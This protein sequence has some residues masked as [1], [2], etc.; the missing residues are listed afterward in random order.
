MRYIYPLV[1]VLFFV[2]LAFAQQ[3]QQVVEPIQQSQLLFVENKGQIADMKGNAHPEILFTT[4]SKSMKLFIT[5]TSIDYQFARTKSLKTQTNTQD[6]TD[7]FYQNQ[8][9]DDSTEIH[10]H[11]VFMRLKDANPKPQIIR[12]QKNSYY[13]NY[14]LPQC[15]TGVTHVSTYEKITFKNVYQNIDWVLYT[16]NGHLKYDFIVHP[17]ANQKDIKLVYEGQDSLLLL[18]DGSLKIVTTLGI[19]Q[20][21]APVIYQQNTKISGAYQL[22]GN[23]LSF[24]IGK[25]NNLLPLTIDPE[26]LWGTY[27]G[28]NGDQDYMTGSCADNKN[29]IYI[30]GSTTST[31]GIALNGHINVY[32][33]GFNDAYLVKFDEDGKRLWA[34]YF[35]GEWS[36]T[37]AEPISDSNLDAYLIF[38]S[39]ST[40][41]LKGTRNQINNAGGFSDNYI[42]K[43]NKDGIFLWGTFYGGEDIDITHSVS[44]DSKSNLLIS[45]VTRSK[46]GIS[47]N[48]YLNTSKSNAWSNSSG[49]FS[50]FDS[51]GNL[52]W[53]SYFGDV[54]RE[55][56]VDNNDDIII[57]GECTSLT[58]SINYN[59]FQSSI[60][61]TGQYEGDAFLAKFSSN[62]NIIWGTYYGGEEFDGEATCSIDEQGNCYLVGRTRSKM[63]IS[64]NGIKNSKTGTFEDGFIT[65]FNKSGQRLWATYI[66]GDSSDGFR[67]VKSTSS[68]DIYVI[69]FTNNNGI[70]LKNPFLKASIKSIDVFDGYIAKL[71]TNGQ[72]EWATLFGSDK[73]DHITHLNLDKK[74]NLLITGETDE[75][76][77]KDFNGFRPEYLGNNNRGPFFIKIKDNPFAIEKVSPVKTNYCVGE[78]LKLTYIAEIGLNTGNIFTFQLSDSSGSF[79]NPLNISTK[80][81]TKKGIDSISITLPNSILSG[82]KYR[83]RVLASD[84]SDI[85]SDY[86][87][88]IIENPKLSINFKG[89]QAACKGDTTVLKAPLYSNYTYQW[90]KDGSIINNE[91]QNTLKT[92]QAGQYYLLAFAPSGCWAFSDTLT[93]TPLATGGIGFSGSTSKCTGDELTF[94]DTS[95]LSINYT[96]QWKPDFMD[97]SSQSVFKYTFN[98]EGQYDLTLHIT[99][100]NGCKDSITKNI[101]ILSKPTLQLTTDKDTLL[102][103]NDS[104]TL[105]INTEVGNTIEWL[106]NNTAIP[107]AFDTLYTTSTKGIYKI[108]VN[109]VGGCSE[110]ISI[111]IDII[112]PPK[113]SFITILKDG[114]SSAPIICSD[115][116][117]ILE[118]RSTIQGNLLW[119]PSNTTG[120]TNSV[121]DTGW[122]YLTTSTNSGCSFKDSVEI[123]DGCD[124]TIFIPNAF[125]PN[126]KDEYNP[127]FKP[128]GTNIIKF[129][130]DIYSIWGEKL[131]ES[132]NINFG[133]DGTHRGINL[134]QGV[135]IY[136]IR[137]TGNTNK[138]H[139]FKSSTKGTLTLI[140]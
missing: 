126:K 105:T 77:L 45:G 2:Q 46:T 85:S 117:E 26:L 29:D 32:S 120:L 87:P 135:Y 34:T 79:A 96:R 109:N 31:L 89:N 131:F 19:I 93:I 118:L 107:Q 42:A 64:F 92:T 115:D 108:V 10:T 111:N 24:T 22:K 16:K 67:G 84:F 58:D 110:E 52:L 49:F 44:L 23:Q 133:W 86:G 72:L 97:T 8:T 40:T 127:T 98:V 55:I 53:A 81:S 138:G 136:L 27:Y 113:Q 66:G 1:F 128:V 38:F 129:K 14:Y 83:L 82:T 25:Y 100:V 51:S 132:N 17:N 122:V 41:G 50:K 36:D 11:R 48:G 59:G 119:Q 121:S 114:E 60:G 78:D 139:T 39:R 37:P 103:P 90:Y 4:G 125:T 61:G 13:E 134:S 112:E 130:M 3:A 28:D 74:R 94:T 35:G 76:K 62:G 99:D 123:K 54:A 33:G 75:H 65:K 18:P 5:A 106:R 15:Q 95:N 104:I 63:G 71:T 73:V 80:A 7:P 20:E 69:G 140:R 21:A 137:Y 68:G 70:Q 116:N 9:L 47:K 101:T 6:Y 43:F 57:S 102:C 91:K 88:I 124:Y 56:A 30:S 12:E